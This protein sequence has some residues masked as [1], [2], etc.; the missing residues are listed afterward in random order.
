[1]WMRSTMLKW[2]CGAGR[3]CGSGVSTGYRRRY[4]GAAG[5]VGLS[6]SLSLS[7]FFFLSRVSVWKEAMATAQRTPLPPRPDFS[8]HLCLSGSALA[9]EPGQPGFWDSLGWGKASV[10]SDAARG[11]L[12][13]EARL[14]CR[15]LGV[16]LMGT[17]HSRGGGSEAAGGPRSCPGWYRVVQQVST[18][19]ALGCC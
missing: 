4:C 8:H 13:P 15:R 2:S 9:G 11:V 1:M 14:V 18:E 17:S 10:C 5:T 19:D 7:F 16:L 3:S 12:Q 6:F